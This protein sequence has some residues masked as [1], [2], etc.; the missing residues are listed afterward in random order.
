MRIVFLLSSIIPLS[1]LLACGPDCQS[2]CNRLYQKDQCSLPTTGSSVDEKVK[3]CLSE[4]NSALETPGTQGEYNP[5]NE[6]SSSERPELT[7]DQQ[8]AAWMDCI[9]NTA[10]QN[11]ESNFC[12]PIW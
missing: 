4:C 12:A 6:T 1:Q 5:N 9:D 7:N 11:L 2:T 8:A 10:C 3:Y